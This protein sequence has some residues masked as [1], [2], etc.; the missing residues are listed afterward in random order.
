[1]TD[2]GRTGYCEEAA[3][4]VLTDLCAWLKS[5]GYTFRKP[6][7]ENPEPGK[8]RTGEEITQPEIVINNFR[9]ELA[10]G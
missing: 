8:W 5:K 1:M 2:C 4:D 7:F 3:Q 6:I 10:E 9:K